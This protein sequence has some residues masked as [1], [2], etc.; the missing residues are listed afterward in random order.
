MQGTQR[1]EG[2]VG[3]IEFE[4][5][6]AGVMAGL[7]MGL[8]EAI[9]SVISGQSPLLPLRGAASIVLQQDAYGH[10]A[11]MIA[12]VGGAVHFSIAVM[13]SFAFGVFNSQLPW[14]TR[15]AAL[16][17]AALGVL[18]GSLIWL[19]NFQVIARIF[20]PWLVEHSQ[21]VQWLLHAFTFG[22][23]L[24]LLFSEREPPLRHGEKPER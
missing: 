16:R 20:Y 17:Q 12:V 21:I 2:V 8:F 15:V 22:L 4:T 5:V 11:P 24:G 10:N 13:Y 3:R 14:F 7:V 6:A 18:F 1:G 19:L 9:A 23:P